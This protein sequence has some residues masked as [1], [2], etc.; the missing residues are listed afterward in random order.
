MHVLIVE[1]SPTVMYLTS[2]MLTLHGFEVTQA[3]DGLEAIEKAKTSLPD[4]IVLDV[5]LPKLNGYHVCRE[6]KSLDETAHIPIIMLTSK[7]READRD[8]GIEQGADV[9]I[10]KPVEDDQLLAALKNLVGEAHD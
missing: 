3:N 7:T 6:L 10:S 8:W 2:R 4:V 1:D 9:Y 5:I